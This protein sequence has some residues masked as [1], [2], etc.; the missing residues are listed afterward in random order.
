MDEGKY[1]NHRFAKLAW[2]EKH[3]PDRLVETF[4]GK[5]LSADA[6]E[7]IKTHFS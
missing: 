1:R 4:E 3:F 7:I 2:Y 5:T 6:N